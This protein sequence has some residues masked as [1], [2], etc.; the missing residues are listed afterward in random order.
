MIF[1]YCA[2]FTTNVCVNSVFII[3]HSCQH[4]IEIQGPKGPYLIEDIRNN[5]ENFYSKIPD[6]ETF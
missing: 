2:I 5:T 3:T 6:K 4:F 1:S